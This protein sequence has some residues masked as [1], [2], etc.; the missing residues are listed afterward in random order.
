MKQ[1][2]GNKMEANIVSNGQMQ[3]LFRIKSMMKGFNS[4]DNLEY[5]L[6]DM[7]RKY[8][9]I[10]DMKNSDN[11][12]EFIADIKKRIAAINLILEA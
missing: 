6:N 9:E 2:K 11:T 1:R 12:K 5:Q 8:L 10:L 4:I 3:N 7:K